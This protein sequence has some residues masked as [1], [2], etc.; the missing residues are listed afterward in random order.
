[1]SIHDIIHSDYDDRP[2]NTSLMLPEWQA[3]PITGRYTV[4]N[5]DLLSVTDPTA[6]YRAM[7][8][9]QVV[10]SIPNGLPDVTNE[11]EVLESELYSEFLHDYV[12][13]G[14]DSSEPSNDILYPI[15]DDDLSSIRIVDDD[16]ESD[17]P[18]VVAMMVRQQQ[19]E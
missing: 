18:P 19:D 2:P 13:P 10:L 8:S 1:M 17:P 16:R 11:K 12:P 4:Y 9:R 15:L 5:W 7:E 14:E 6:V 3:T